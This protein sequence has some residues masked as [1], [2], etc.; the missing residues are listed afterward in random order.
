[1]KGRLCQGQRYA[2]IFL[3]ALKIANLRLIR[4]YEIITNVK[5]K[6]KVKDLLDFQSIITI[7]TM[8]YWVIMVFVDNFKI[9]EILM[10]LL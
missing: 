5:F 7:P 4:Y 8:F 2:R 1:M 3:N 10:T 9:C 6:F